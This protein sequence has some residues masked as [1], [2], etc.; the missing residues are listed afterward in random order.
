MTTTT[1]D[2]SIADVLPEPADGTHLVRVEYDGTHTVIWRDDS[3][4]IS[5][6]PNERWLNDQDCD[7]ME[8]REIL[9]YATA[10]HAISEKPLAT[11][12]PAKA[13]I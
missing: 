5:Q 8:W 6:Y 12:P 11:M 3:A 13:D 7:A 4:R 9:R 2:T 1:T 10:V